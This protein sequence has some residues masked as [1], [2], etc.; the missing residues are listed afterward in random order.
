MRKVFGIIG[1]ATAGILGGWL[2]YKYVP[3]SEHTLTGRAMDWI[4]DA[5]VGVKTRVAGLFKKKHS[6]GQAAA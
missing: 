6:P 2:L 1:I 4:V 5:V 3:T